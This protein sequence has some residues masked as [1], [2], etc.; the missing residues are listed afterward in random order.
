MRV[1]LTFL[2]VANSLYL[3]PWRINPSVVGVDAFVTPAALLSKRQNAFQNKDPSYAKK[4][5]EYTIDEDDD[6]DDDGGD[7]DGAD[8]YGTIDSN[9]NLSGDYILLDTEPETET[10]HGDTKAPR[11]TEYGALS[12]GTVVQVQVGDISAGR[13]AWKKRRRSGSPLL[14]P[15]SVLNVDRKSMVRWNL[16]FLLEK[17]G[18]GKKDGISISDTELTKRY[19]T[20]LQSSLQ[21]RKTST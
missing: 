6:D 5:P 3:L 8:G 11:Q 13:K 10:N 2:L 1:C 16:I 15:C 14:V 18:V 21:V 20:F 19:R 12:P 7:Y 4:P 17:F 9:A